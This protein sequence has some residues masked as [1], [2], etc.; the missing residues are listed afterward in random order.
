MQKNNRIYGLDALRAIAMLL[1]IVLHAIIAYKVYPNPAWPS[2][3][4][5]HSYAFD[6]LYVFI[7]SFRMQLFYLV[8]GFFARMLY[9]KIGETAFFKHRFKRIGIPFIASMIFILPISIA[10]FLYNQYVVT[11]GLP[12]EEG[13]ATFWRR[14]FRWNG[15]AH[16]WFL[17]YL[18]FY[19]AVMLAAY[20]I[21]PGDG[22]KRMIGRVNSRYGSPLHIL[23]YII[24]LACIQIALF[25]TP[26]V[27]VSTSIFPKPG[28]FTYY[29]FFFLLGI[30]LHR[31]SDRL[32]GIAKYTWL[33]LGAGLLLTVVVFKMLVLGHAEVETYSRQMMLLA[34]LAVAAQTV[35][36]TYGF[37]GFFLKYMNVE[38]ATLKYISDASFWLYLVH[39][40][41]VGTLQIVLLYTDVPGWLRPWTVLAVTTVV[42][43]VTYH[44]FVRYT[45]IGT[46]LH[47]QR[48]REG[49]NATVVHS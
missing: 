16:L 12:A 41:I 24:I 8:A 32:F 10:P 45:F 17:Y 19:Y 26:E 23:L 48:K 44:W 35:L 36:L 1:G 31:Q 33:Y 15:M 6:A 47:G 9:L 38:N 5:L 3:N 13:M 37:I 11:S 46:A 43:M 18:L 20:R 14:L 25:P 40:S 49:K 21:R 34:K 29:G 4:R 22:V 2:D 30:M 28:H 42:A 39:L 7:H 27:E